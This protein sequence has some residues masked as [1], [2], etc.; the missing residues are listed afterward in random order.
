MDRLE[1]VGLYSAG[2]NLFLVALKLGLASLS[3]SLA[4]AADAIHSLV[5]VVASLVVLAGLFIAR[6]TSRSFPYGLYKVENLVSVL[7]ALLI[8]LA[9]YEIAREAFLA[10]PHDLANA[11][12][13]LGGVALSILTVFAFGRYERRLGKATNSPSLVA[14]SEHFRVDMLASGVVFVAILGNY[15]GVPLDRLGSGVVVLFVLWA[16]WGILV[17]GMRV[18]LDASLD[19]ETLARVRELIAAEP[20][21]AEVRSLVGRN[22]GRY[23][24]LETEIAV[25][26]LDLTKAHQLSERLEES[27]KAKVPHVDRVV[28]HCEP[29]RRDTSRW[30]VPLESPEGA[31]SSHLGK[32]PYVALVDV[33]P[34]SGE[35][36]GYEVLGNPYLGE[37]RQK[38]LKLAEFLARR[39]VDGLA[40]RESLD[41]RGPAYVLSAA[42]VEA[43]QTRGATLDEVLAELRAESASPTA[44][45]TQ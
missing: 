15:V 27:I 42:G 23:K 10:P 20:G 44:S 21:V 19:Q 31:V 13:A 30:A 26:T 2:V 11:P 16:G 25:R 3:G 17:D 7:V 1:R 12:L 32:A 24:F 14:D 38:G 34:E 35:V 8:F 45:E 33:R 29:R 4:L 22:S 18:L 5:D 6:R 39:G 40:L 41:G 28:I 9:G 37:D 43:R 36:L